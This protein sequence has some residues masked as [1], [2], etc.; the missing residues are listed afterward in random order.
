MSNTND[1]K[2]TTNDSTP[3]IPNNSPSSNS[4]NKENWSGLISQFLISG[5]ISTYAIYV[6]L[7]YANDPDK[8]C[9]QDAT[10]LLI[11]GIISWS[12]MLLQWLSGCLLIKKVN[13]GDEVVVST[14]TAVVTGVTTSLALFTMAWTIYGFV[15]FFNLP[16]CPQGE[17]HNFG[18]IIAIVGIV[19]LSFTVCIVCCLVTCTSDEVGLKNKLITFFTTT[20][21][22]QKREEEEVK[23]KA[24]DGNS[25]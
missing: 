24:S 17:A 5:A 7:K 25:V 1:A 4:E 16:P 21:A 6:G 8:Q 23:Q 2:D 11:F 15:V 19:V 14:F 12:A 20:A 9:Q 22:Q 10:W 3:L 18:K 13:S